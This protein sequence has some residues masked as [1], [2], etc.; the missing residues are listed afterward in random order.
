M[1]IPKPDTPR[2]KALSQTA[3]PKTLSLNPKPSNLQSLTLNGLGLRVY[4][5]SV[6]GSGI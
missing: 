3:D 2:P 6:Q 1:F 5:F 4:R